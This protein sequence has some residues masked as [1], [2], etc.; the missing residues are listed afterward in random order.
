MLI[1]SLFRVLGWPVRLR[2]EAPP[3]MRLAGILGRF[4]R[5]I[6]SIPID[7]PVATCLLDRHALID[8]EEGMARRK[9]AQID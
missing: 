2:R 1:C 8:A 3:P 6:G 5:C 9:R 7:A 4:E